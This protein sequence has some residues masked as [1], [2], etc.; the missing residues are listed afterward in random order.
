MAMGK[1][2]LVVFA[3]LW[4]VV[5]STGLYAATAADK[6]GTIVLDAD[7]IAAAVSPTMKI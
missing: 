6:S 4:G 7:D 5:L 1:R 3:V 2:A